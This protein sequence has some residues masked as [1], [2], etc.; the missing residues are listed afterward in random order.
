MRDLPYISEGEYEAI[1]HKLRPTSYEL[2]GD[3]YE[4]MVSSPLNLRKAPDGTTIE[5]IGNDRYMDVDTRMPYQP[6]KYGTENW[7]HTTPQNTPDINPD[8][9]NLDKMM[10]ELQETEDELKT[11]LMRMEQNHVATP[12]EEAK[13][14]ALLGKQAELKQAISQKQ[15]R[16]SHGPARR[17]LHGAADLA[18]R[19]RRSLGASGGGASRKRR[20]SRKKKR[21][22]RKKKKKSTKRRRR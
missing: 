9:Y 10:S 7:K 15:A 6:E 2:W 1:R 18:S 12:A 11:M 8:A 3:K 20:K 19:L 17:L 16:A 21:K 5:Y 4:N 14:Q 22:S 13:E